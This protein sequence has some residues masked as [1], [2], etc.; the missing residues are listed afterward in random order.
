MLQ[1]KM[2]WG[3]LDKWMHRHTKCDPLTWKEPS[4]KW[5]GRSEDT[6][7]R[8]K[9]T[10]VAAHVL[11]IHPVFPG[12]CNKSQEQRYFATMISQWLWHRLRQ[13]LWETIHDMFGY[14]EGGTWGVTNTT[15]SIL[16]CESFWATSPHPFVASE[17]VPMYTIT[18]INFLAT[19]HKI[20]E[21]GEWLEFMNIIKSNA[22]VIRW[23]SHEICRM[24]SHKWRESKVMEQ[25][26]TIP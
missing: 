10:H 11:A 14:Q 12:I 18:Q 21:S 26:N 20:D 7:T 19:R 4:E 8:C 23:G 16:C 13:Y 5:S 24:C 25:K 15:W 6:S 17:A 3:R 2:Q 1:M 22:I 9:P